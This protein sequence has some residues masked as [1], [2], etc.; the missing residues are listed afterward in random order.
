MNVDPWPPGGSKPW[1]S[2]PPTG[3]AGH[4]AV[5]RIEAVLFVKKERRFT[6]LAIL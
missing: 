2:A 4:P 5:T 6:R 3:K 1:S